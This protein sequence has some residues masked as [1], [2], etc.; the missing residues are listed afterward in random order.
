[1]VQTRA[2]L[3][4]DLSSGELAGDQVAEE[5]IDP[6]PTKIR[7]ISEPKL[8]KSKIDNSKPMMG[9][10]AQCKSKDAKASSFANSPRPDP[11]SDWAGHQDVKVPSTYEEVKDLEGYPKGL[12][13]Y[14]DNKSRII[15]P[16]PKEQRARLIMQEH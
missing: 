11:L 7:K 14:K 15:I 13:V 10:I 12:L 1:M 3:A 2:Q 9:P 5:D 16:V 8:G 6:R 4:A